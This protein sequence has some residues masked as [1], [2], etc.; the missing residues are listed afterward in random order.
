MKKILDELYKLT[1]D[2]FKNNLPND[3]I[4]TLRKEKRRKEIE[5]KLIEKELKKRRLLTFDKSKG[6]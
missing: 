5:I 4:K 1:F 3:T 6:T 2:L